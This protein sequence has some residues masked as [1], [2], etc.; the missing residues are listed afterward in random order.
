LRVAISETT[1]L[2][3]PSSQLLAGLGNL[4]PPATG[5]AS[6]TNTTTTPHAPA[7]GATISG[8]TAYHG[9]SLPFST[10]IYG[11]TSDAIYAR[12]PDELP[13]VHAGTQ[14]TRT[15]NAQTDFQPLPQAPSGNPAS[16]ISPSV[17]AAVQQF[18]ASGGPRPPQYAPPPP[19]P[20]ATGIM[21]QPFHHP[22]APSPYN[23]QVAPAALTS[24]N[25]GDT[26]QAMT[27]LLALL[28]R[29]LP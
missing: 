23:P 27:Q 1:S 19:P 4:L 28:V 3:N 9:N 2:T 24:S 5:L 7:T 29:C 11:R 8:Q 20:P 18:N 15:F 13:P 25:N 10:G 16:V 22:N 6:R 21:R 12:R 17:F 14:A 26:T